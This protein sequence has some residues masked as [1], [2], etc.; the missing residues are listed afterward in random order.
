MQEAVYR[1]AR[2]FF[3]QVSMDTDNGTEPTFDEAEAA[4]LRKRINTEMPFG[5]LPSGES[6]APYDTG[7]FGPVPSDTA[8]LRETFAGRESESI[9]GQEVVSLAQN[10]SLLSDEA[11]QLLLPPCLLW[12]LHGVADDGGIVAEFVL[13]SLS[14]TQ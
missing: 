4:H 5:K 10:L 7:R 2:D 6:L 13:Y 1:E 11:Y 12:C 9:T 3:R 14:P 8:W